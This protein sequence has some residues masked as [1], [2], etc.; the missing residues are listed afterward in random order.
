MTGEINIKTHMRKTMS[1][2][3]NKEGHAHN[4]R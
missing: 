3:T 2:Q 4:N 1:K